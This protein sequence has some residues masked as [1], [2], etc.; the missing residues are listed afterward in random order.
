ME[1]KMVI[2]YLQPEG[3]HKP[4]GEYSHGVCVTQGSFLFISGQVGV[5]S[6]GELVGKGDIRAQSKQAFE[7]VRVILDSAGVTF[8][9][10]VKLVAFVRHAQDVKSFKEIK[11][12]Y[13]CKPYPADTIIVAELP[14]ED[15]LLEMDVIAVLE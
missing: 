12:Q 1:G 15:W 2:K 11:A 6:A 13:V 5:N 8:K 10:V 4:I 3:L 7:N 9:N 14:K